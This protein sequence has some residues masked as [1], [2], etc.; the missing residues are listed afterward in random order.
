MLTDAGLSLRLDAALRDRLGACADRWDRDRL[1]ERVWDRDASVWT[2]GD[3]ADWLGWLE[4]PGAAPVAELTS[5]SREVAAAGMTDVLV[6]GMGGSSLCPEV[7]GLV[8]GSKNRRRL[9]VLDSTDPAQ[10]RRVLDQVEL[11]S[12]L[13]IVSSKSGSTLESATLAD[14]VLD[15]V[16]AAVGADEA[17]RRCLAIT[18]AG[19]A[20]ETRARQAGVHQV[21]HGDASIGGRFSALSSFG[22][23]PAA[24]AGLDVIELLARAAAMAEACGRDRPASSNPGAVLG[25]LLGVAAQ[26]GRDKAT[27]LLSPGMAPLGWWLEQLIAESTGKDGRG[28]IPI[29]DEPVGA[30]SSYGADR[31]FVHLRLEAEREPSQDRAV[32]R[33]ADAG[34]P[35]AELRLP[36]RQAIGGEFFRWE[37]ATAVCG[38]VLGVHPFDQPNVQEAKDATKAILASGSIEDPGFDDLGVLLKQVGEGDYVAILAYLDRTSET[39]DAIE[40]VRVAIRGNATFRRRA[41]ARQIVIRRTSLL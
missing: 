13:C 26:A 36:D 16:T 28:I 7:L 39:E 2:G 23:V 9:R 4:A 35:V 40:R 20:L 17:G 32:A 15:R 21:W 24:A 27:L 30:P 29:V 11:S 12:T 1:V 33:L 31:L 5:L 6:L 34:H 38:A 22:L 3:E 18:D 25:L 8:L 37:M 41:V 19:S 10:I 14:Y